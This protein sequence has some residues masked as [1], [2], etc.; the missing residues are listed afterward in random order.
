MN[1]DVDS[2]FWP[3]YT[4]K[5][6][7]VDLKDAP[8]LTGESVGDRIRINYPTI[9]EKLISK[10]V[11]ESELR[12]RKEAMREGQY[13]KQ[14]LLV[15]NGTI[16]YPLLGSETCAYLCRAWNDA[17]AKIV[18]EDDSFIGIAQ[19]SHMD[20]KTAA[21]EA[22]RAVRDLGFRA[23]EIHGRW[24][25]GK[26]V[27]SPDWFPFFERISKLGVPLW[28]HSAGKTTTK[29]Y[30]SY[31]P[32]N[33]ILKGFPPYVNSLFGFLIHTQLVIA[34]LIFGG[35]FDK[36]P[37]LKVAMTECDAGWVPSVMDWLDMIYEAGLMRKQQGIL[38]EWVTN[39]LQQDLR[40]RKKPSQYVRDN[41]SFT[42]A[43]TNGYSIEKTLPFLVNEIGLEDNLLVES[44]YDQSEGS[45]DIVRRVM[46]ARGISQE[47]KEKICGRNAAQLLKV[48][49]A[50]SLYA[51]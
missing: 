34:G 14:C 21:D 40:L 31:V 44:D 39:P 45:F 43:S 8:R 27:E 15:Q 22:E 28:F 9:G 3:M 4:F 17:V 7:P 36:F 30:N 11:T 48:K 5:D 29:G 26:N 49:W 25:T 32:A 42:L 23:V 46:E 12:A 1:I 51:Q 10:W 24:E 47:A 50:P 41:F 33:D 37:D 2:H 20:P 18:N 19:V 13:D 38:Y 35:V 6:T 16:V